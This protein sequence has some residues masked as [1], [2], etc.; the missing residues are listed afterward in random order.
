MTPIFNESIDQA[1]SAE[2]VTR[3]RVR[4]FP[5]LIGVAGLALVGRTV[6]IYTG[7]D[8]MFAAAQAEEQETTATTEGQDAATAEHA[9]D[10]A[11]PVADTGAPAI[12]GLPSSEEMELLSQ[13]RQRR[14]E[15]DKRAREL[16]EQE[17]TLLAF[18]KRIDDKIGQLKVLEEQVKSHLKVFEDQEAEQLASIVKVYETMPAKE[19]APRFEM[20]GLETQMD[21]VTR[22]KPLKVAALMAKMSPDAAS[23][24]TTELANVAQA[25]NLEDIQGNN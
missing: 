8:L 19:A 13:L 3:R 1:P 14:L 7:V 25:P 5:L 21:L 4:L 2:I 12:I 23:R 6:D 22:M 10:A 11:A 15:L 20:L 17:K 24:L 16:D 9:A 18:E